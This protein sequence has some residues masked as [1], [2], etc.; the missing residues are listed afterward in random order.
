MKPERYKLLKLL[1]TLLKKPSP[2]WKP[3]RKGLR[4]MWRVTST[5]P[6]HDPLKTG[7]LL[8]L[9]LEISILSALCLDWDLASSLQ[10]GNA[11][12]KKCNRIPSTPKVGARLSWNTSWGKKNAPPQTLSFVILLRDVFR[13]VKLL[14]ADVTN[15]ITKNKILSEMVAN[16]FP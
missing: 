6:V 10:K 8:Q 13:T 4:C 11:S 15:P 9:Y 5:T 2:F 14:V 1:W 12:W 7:L 16:H 3:Q